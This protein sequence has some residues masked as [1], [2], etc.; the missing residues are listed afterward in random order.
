M[1]I[2]HAPA[3]PSGESLSLS[4]SLCWLHKG[5]SKREENRP[6]EVEPLPFLKAYRNTKHSQRTASRY[7]SFQSYH[8]KACLQDISVQ[9]FIH[10]HFN[11]NDSFVLALFCHKWETLPVLMLKCEVTLEDLRVLCHLPNKS[12]GNILDF[13][14]EVTTCLYLTHEGHMTNI[15]AHKSCKAH[16]YS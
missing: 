4:L 5:P 2:K 16:T 15:L 3:L 9:L 13:T 12:F 1:C 7:Y 6:V 14:K 8:L 10:Y 11:E